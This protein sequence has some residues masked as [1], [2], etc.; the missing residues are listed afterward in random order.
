[1]APATA[2]VAAATEQKHIDQH[3][4]VFELPT[5][6]MKMIHDAIPPHC[7]KPSTLRSMAYVFRDYLY[8][9]ILV[10]AATYIQYI[11]N[12][13]ARGVAWAAYSVL[14]GFV[15]TGIWILAHECGHGAFSKSRKLNNFM[16]LLLHS[17]LLVPYH[18]WRITH[19]AHHKATGNIE[20]DTA[21]VPHLRDSWVKSHCG[22]NAQTESVE[23]SHLAEDAP[24][25]TLWYCIKHQLFGWPGHM[26]ANLTGQKYDK[27]F[28]QFSHFYFGEDSVLF[29]KEQLGLIMLTDLVLGGMI[30]LL[31]IGGQIFGSWNMVLYYVI[32][33]LWVNHWIGKHPSHPSHR[34]RRRN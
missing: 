17:F 4:N 31:I 27:G 5:Y 16:G 26:F 8:A 25:V 9:S 33:Y 20:K 15:F 32:P 24:M 34:H 14:Q 13:Y 18:S 12:I 21:F 10:Y 6:T 7:F 1:M 28:P 30:A 23:L 22:E 11:P 2:S 29:K 3:G 19:S